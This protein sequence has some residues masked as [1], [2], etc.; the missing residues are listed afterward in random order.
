[1]LVGEGVMPRGRRVSVGGRGRAGGRAEVGGGGVRRV[2][3][4][5]VGQREL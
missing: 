2:M 3:R 4:A 1:M 5:V